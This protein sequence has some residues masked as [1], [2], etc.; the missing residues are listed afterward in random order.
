ML[1]A[2]IVMF[3]FN[4]FLCLV[5]GKLFISIRKGEPGLKLGLGNSK[6]Y[7]NI[8]GQQVIDITVILNLSSSV[9]KMIWSRFYSLGGWLGFLG[10]TSTLF[11]NT[12]KRTYLMIPEFHHQNNK[13]VVIQYRY[14]FLVS[15]SIL[16][17]S[18]DNDNYIGEK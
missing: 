7:L 6:T 18:T 16:G 17:K 15:L 3:R 10:Y 9:C 12:P 8:F 5:L 1:R 11:W 4:R 14:R 13:Q 2:N